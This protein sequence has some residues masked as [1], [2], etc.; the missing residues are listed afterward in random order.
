M[1][2][3]PKLE[4]G[5]DRIDNRLYTGQLTGPGTGQGINE[6]RMGIESTLKEWELKI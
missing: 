5:Y 2:K 6:N 3:G 1:R 4:L